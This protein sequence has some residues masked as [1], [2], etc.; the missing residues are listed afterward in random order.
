MAVSWTVKRTAVDRSDTLLRS[1]LAGVPIGL[2]FLLIAQLEKKWFLILFLGSLILTA[3]FVFANKKAYY[4]ALL[5]ASLP[6]AIDVNLYFH[7]STISHSTYGFP[8]RLTAIPLAMLYLMWGS[9]S[10]VQKL[11]FQASTTGLLPLAGFLMSACLSVL[12]A[13]N[14]LFGLFDLFALTFS[15]LLF[16]YTASEIRN[17][18]EM[19][20][21]LSV[22]VASVALQGLIAIGQ[23][24]T[25]STLGLEFF[26]ASQNLQSAA[27]LQTLTRVGGTLGHPNSLA[28]FLDLMLPL[29][30]SLLFG[31]ISGRVKL[32]VLAAVA[33]GIAGLGVTL[34]RG[35]TLSV[36]L[37]LPVILLVHWS[38]HVGFLRSGF[39]VAAASLFLAV[40][41]LG[42]SNPIQQRLF[43]D[44]YGTASGR[45]PHVQVAFNLIRARPFFGVG[46]NNY[47]ETARLY[48]NTP[49]QI[50]SQWNSPVH[51]LLLFIA[52][53]TGL[54]GLGFFLLFLLTIVL[55]LFPAL[56]CP[57]PLLSSVGLG[58]L[59]GFLAYCIHV[60]IDYANWSHFSIFWFLLGL[61]VSVSRL[62]HSA[63]P[64]PGEGQ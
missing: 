57:D 48:D 59:M 17:V 10:L 41:V 9:R 13:K 45:V 64:S 60:Q 3:S 32:F 62:A 44:D 54:T 35:G 14:Q 8:I 19:R 31:P 2:L 38:R 7:P 23:H 42:T 61:A 43:Q 55:A 51:N 40:L 49:E 34:S 37:V 29:S 47:T 52:G 18:R 39:A 28:L 20:L 30:F 58:L 5:V 33:L 53:E 46:L 16:F 1:L 4:L 22:L 21:V 56:R 50:V 26:G 6:I 36:G 63:T 15:L 11:P 12:F 27:G 24:V 25:K